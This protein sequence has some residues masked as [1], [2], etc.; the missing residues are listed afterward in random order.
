MKLKEK[1]AI[2]TGAASGIG[3]AVA[4]LMAE[5]GAGVVVN[6]IDEQQAEMVAEQIHAKSGNA[7]SIKA[8]VTKLEDIK[9]MIADT[10][11]HF[12]KIDILVNNAGG[13]PAA[14]FNEISMEELDFMLDLN[15]KSAV[16]CTR[17]VIE[18]M[19]ERK[20]GNIINIASI[21]GITGAAGM[22]PYSAAKAGIIG[23]TKALAKETAAYGIRVNSVSPGAIITPATEALTGHIEVMKKNMYLSRMG[24]PEDIA[25]QVV[26]LVSEAGGFIV[27]QNIVVD[28][29]RSLG[30]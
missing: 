24:Q 1:I 28:G 30:W 8:D 3:K 22:V 15:L 10:L 29:G 2:V 17:C 6:D 23:F 9:R 7:I 21:C 25:H 13:G 5:E 20:S 14:R 19:T 11:E 4:I 16:Y 18:H 12:G 27:G 26:F